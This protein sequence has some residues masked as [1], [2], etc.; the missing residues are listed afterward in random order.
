MKTIIITPKKPA[1]MEDSHVSKCM[2]HFPPIYISLPQTPF[3]P[4]LLTSLRHFI[5]LLLF[6]GWCILGE[7]ALE[8]R[9]QSNKLVYRKQEVKST[10]HLLHPLLANNEEGCCLQPL[11]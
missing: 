8:N 3:A 1:C 11:N 7:T 4:F 6:G 2:S 5:E 10:S 9:L